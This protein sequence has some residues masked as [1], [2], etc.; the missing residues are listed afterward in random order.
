VHPGA[1]AARA[2]TPGP[3]AKDYFAHIPSIIPKASRLT[4]VEDPGAG[5]PG[6]AGLRARK[7]NDGLRSV[8]GGGHFPPLPSEPRV[9]G[10]SPGPGTRLP[11]STALARDEY[12]QIIGVNPDRV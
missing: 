10:S 8:G 2:N 12:L 9:V 3:H 6:T 1:F 5:P 7:G 11:R 4:S